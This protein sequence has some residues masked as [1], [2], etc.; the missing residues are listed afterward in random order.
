MGCSGDLST[1]TRTT[2]DVLTGTFFGWNG[3]P[4]SQHGT[5]GDISEREMRRIRAKQ[6]NAVTR[7][8]PI[9]MTTAASR[10]CRSLR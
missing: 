6:I 9:T 8:V 5:G 10:R 3:R 4:S 2:R 7:L 1:A